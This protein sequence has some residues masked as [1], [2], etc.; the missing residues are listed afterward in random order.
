VY[1]EKFELEDEPPQKSQISGKN[2]KKTLK[3]FF[4]K[5]FT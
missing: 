2:E 5:D 1:S 4:S 3:T